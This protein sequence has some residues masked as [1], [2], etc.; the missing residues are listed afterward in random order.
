MRDRASCIKEN[1]LYDILL[2]AKGLGV[3]KG[4]GLERV[5]SIGKSNKVLGMFRN[6]PGMND[7]LSKIDHNRVLDLYPQ[8]EYIY[9][10]YVD[11]DQ[12][13]FNTVYLL[14][15]NRINGANEICVLYA[16]RVQLEHEA[17]QLLEYRAQMR[18]EQE[19]RR[20]MDTKGKVPNKLG[21]NCY[22]REYP[23][24]K[25]EL[26]KLER[27]Y[28][29]K[30][31]GS[32]RY[33]TLRE[34][35][36]GTVTMSPG[37]H[38]HVSAYRLLYELHH[39]KRRL[40]SHQVV[41]PVNGKKADLRVENVVVRDLEKEDSEMRRE[42]LEVYGLDTQ[43]LEK[44]YAVTGFNRIRGI[45]TYDGANA[46]KGNIGRKYVKLVKDGTDEQ[47]TILL[48][49]ALI[50]VREDRVLTEDETVDHIDHN[51]A[52]DKL[53]N[54]R[55]IGRS[56]HTAED[57]VRLEYNPLECGVCGKHFLPSVKV[58]S[59]YKLNPYIPTCTPKCRH[60]ARDITG[61]ERLAKLAQKKFVQRYYV[62]DKS[63]V[64]GQNTRRYFPEGMD[65]NECRR[66][67][68]SDNIR[69]FTK[70]HSPS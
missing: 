29:A 43:A 19:Y 41:S 38:M 13:E 44:I 62:L 23:W 61:D 37:V 30:K 22:Y 69:A 53:E 11:S 27:I 24:S 52:N 39:A 28:K 47:H 20:V 9:G 34:N 10:P 56:A 26:N 68:H 42:A 35:F 49:R 12:D 55:L 67:L 4:Q 1:P 51:S 16:N 15:T 58:Y 57:S 32:F 6:R 60:L 46:H 40:E 5:Y 25:E 54:L 63:P 14:F 64:N 3:S 65:Y 7:D 36:I 8:Y 70:P 66:L 18:D 31:V 50:A 21:N 33:N 48:S 45:Y 2:L 17:G 59:Y